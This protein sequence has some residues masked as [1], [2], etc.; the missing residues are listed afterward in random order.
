MGIHLI[1]RAVYYNQ[2]D[3]KWSARE[4]ITLFLFAV[5]IYGANKVANSSAREFRSLFPIIGILSLSSK[6]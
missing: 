2:Y 5:D 1:R 6:S 4:G 3:F